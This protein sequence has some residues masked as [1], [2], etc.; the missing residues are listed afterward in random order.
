[1]HNTNILQLAE[2]KTCTTQISYTNNI[3]CITQIFY[4]E[5][6]IKHALHK[7]LKRIK[8][9]LQNYLSVSKE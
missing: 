6:R 8:H 1:M 9:A 4:S 7:Y 3:T 5:L 2:N